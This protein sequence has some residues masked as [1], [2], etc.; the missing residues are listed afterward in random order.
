MKNSM[1]VTRA[2]DF[3]MTRFLHRNRQ[4]L[5]GA[6]LLAVLLLFPC[7]V[8]WA[9]GG[10]GSYGGMTGGDGLPTEAD[11]SSCHDDL[12]RFPFLNETNANKHHVLIDTQIILPTAPPGVEPGETYDCYFCHS[13]DWD[14]ET[15]SYTLSWFRDCLVCH[16]VETVSGPPR[17][18]GSNRHHELGYRCSVCHDQRR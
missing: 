7:A 11:C 4:L 13:A 14:P 17:M 16:P 5:A 15:Y 9:Y 2:T 1:Y 12:I 6:C 10:G 8:S 3:S 18:Q